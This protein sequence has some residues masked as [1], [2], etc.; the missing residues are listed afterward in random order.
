MALALTLAAPQ[1]VVRITEY[2]AS[3]S[4]PR[5]A[6]NFSANTDGPVA[7]DAVNVMH[8]LNLLFDSIVNSSDPQV[9]TP[10]LNGGCHVVGALLELFR[11]LN[12]LRKGPL[13]TWFQNSSLGLN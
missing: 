1:S 2:F 11:L 9:A 13:I 8:V 4:A 7:L 6:D 3:Q 12:G 5:A 10:F